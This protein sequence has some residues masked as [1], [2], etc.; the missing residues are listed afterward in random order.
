L[1]LP[2]S[3]PKDRADI[4]NSARVYE[5]APVSDSSPSESTTTD[6]INISVTPV[7]C[8]IV[9]SSE[10]TAKFFAHIIESL[11]PSVRGSVSISKEEF[12]AIQVDGEGLDAGQVV[13]DLTSPLAFAKV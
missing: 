9:C 11:D 12:V 2:E 8:S 7:E 4:K 3:A 13:L 5:D 6:F 1:I 10:A